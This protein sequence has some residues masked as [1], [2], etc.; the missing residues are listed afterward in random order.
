MDQEDVE[1]LKRDVLSGTVKK[2]LE[3]QLSQLL[4]ES[5]KRSA[6]SKPDLTQTHEVISQQK[7]SLAQ[8]LDVF[9][10]ASVHPG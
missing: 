6:L 7:N 9:L 4:D 8:E 10:I 1:R 2:M 3:L 5:A